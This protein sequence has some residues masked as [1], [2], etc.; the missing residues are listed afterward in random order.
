[1]HSVINNPTTEH[2]PY[3]RLRWGRGGAP[4]RPA[5]SLAATT[6]RSAS[7]SAAPTRRFAILATVRREFQTAE[8]TQHPKL[9]QATKQQ[10]ATLHNI[11][12][13]QQQASAQ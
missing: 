10:V 4:L 7:P 1:M 3:G 2:I 13:V 11:V 8:V 5:A 6:T 9:S 12:I